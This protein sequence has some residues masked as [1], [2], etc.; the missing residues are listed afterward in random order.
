MSALDVSVQA[1]IL[2]LLQDLQQTL[3]LAYLFI[4]HDLSVVEHIS[5]S[6]AVMYVGKL[7]EFAPTETIFHFPKHRIHSAADERAASFADGAAARSVLGG[8]VP[9]SLPRRQVVDST[10]LA[11]L[12]FNSARDLTGTH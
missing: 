9:A 10:V 12:P 2:N 4:S 1:Q 6:V 7:V 5:D 11:P 8:E 3:G